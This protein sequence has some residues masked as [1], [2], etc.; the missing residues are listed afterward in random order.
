[1]PFG[2]KNAGATYQILVNR[3]FKK[4]LGHI[5]EAYVDDMVVKSVRAANHV[6]D[7]ESFLCPQE[8][9]DET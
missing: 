3:M 4:Q 7:L 1:M 9:W 8:I 5:M 2:L 6:R